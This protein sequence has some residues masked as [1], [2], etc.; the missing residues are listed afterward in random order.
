MTELEK[1]EYAKTFIDKLANGINP[2][3]DT[4]VPSGDIV[5]NVRLTRCF[6]YVSDILRQVIENGGTVP[7]KR[8]KAAKQDFCLTA[9]EKTALSLSDLPLSVSEIAN[10]LNG[11]V[12]LEVTKKISA[13]AINR[14]LMDK[15]YLTEIEINGRHSK[16]PTDS[17]MLLGIYAEEKT[18]QYGTYT[19]VYHKR[20]S[21]QYIVDNI[22]SI[23]ALNNEK[24]EKPD[25]TDAMA[26]FYGRP[27]KEEHD[28]R[29]TELFR[30][31]ATVSEMAFALKRTENGVTS[32]IKK[33]GLY[34]PQNND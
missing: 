12:D 29:L 17:G 7:A 25:G 30:S 23:V 14:W 27:W 1:I 15:G 16:V 3:D 22:E 9:E 26:E 20:S 24:K 28:A 4:P 33:L 13:A 21:Q 8:T 11:A 10:L 6:F 2:I 31:G 34:S 5:N 18:G 32:R 19:S